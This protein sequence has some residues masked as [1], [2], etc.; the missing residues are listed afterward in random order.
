MKT[1]SPLLHNGKFRFPAYPQVKTI[2]PVFHIHKYIK[3]TE[4][5]R[6]HHHKRLFLGYT[7]PHNPVIKDTFSRWTK[8]I[9][10]EAEINTKHYRKP[11][12]EDKYP[13]IILKVQ[14]CKLKKY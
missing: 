11:I 3:E 8:Q 7:K 12:E 4:S 2:C 9:L 6:K 1:S 5:L 14:S 13:I 10:Q